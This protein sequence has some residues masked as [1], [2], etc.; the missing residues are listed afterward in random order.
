MNTINAGSTLFNNHIS[1]MKG[2][3]NMDSNKNIVLIRGVSGSGKSTIGDL[4][5][6]YTK[7]RELD[8]CASILTIATDDMFYT[9]GKYIFDPS[10]LSEYHHAT[11]Q[12]VVTHMKQHDE[13]GLIF[14]CNTFTQEWEM[15]PYMEAADIYDYRVHTIIV[16]NRH[17]SDSIHNVPLPAVAAQ[18]KRFEVIL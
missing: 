9:D 7:T 14:V 1:N 8:E 5:N 4:M 10:K 2:D 11:L 17:G 12:L 16:E 15:K 13:M 3:D 18:M 6:Y